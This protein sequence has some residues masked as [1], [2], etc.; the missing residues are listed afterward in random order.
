M[1]APP[2]RTL[3]HD[4]PRRGGDGEAAKRKVSCS[5]P[6]TSDSYPTVS[7]EASSTMGRK[8]VRIRR[9]SRTRLNSSS[10]LPTLVSPVTSTTL[11]RYGGFCARTIAWIHS[12]LIDA[13]GSRRDP[14]PCQSCPFVE[15][16]TCPGPVF[17]DIRSS[18]SHPVT[19]DGVPP[20]RPT[21]ATGRRVRTNTNAGDADFDLPGS[22]RGTR[23]GRPAT[24]GRRLF[25]SGC[26]A[27]A[28]QCRLVPAPPHIPVRPA[29]PGGVRGGIRLSFVRV[30]VPVFRVG[31]RQPGPIRA[32]AVRDPDPVASWTVVGA[33][34][35]A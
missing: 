21:A 35:A 3:R 19:S 15:A 5:G 6:R 34:V 29:P 22:L 23:R 27:I 12:G 16:Y 25:R 28:R 26:L 2:S 20:P 8:T 1:R 10:T 33:A 30:V 31:C 11:F 7:P 18:P 14:I 24:S 13:S 4:R 9:A 17:A 32:L